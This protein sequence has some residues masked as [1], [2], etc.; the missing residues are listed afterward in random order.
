[1]IG[2]IDYGLGNVASVIN[3]LKKINEHD[4]IFSNNITELGKCEKLILPGVGAFEKGMENLKKANLISFLKDKVE[5]DQIP[6]LGICL[7][8][9]LLTRFSEEGDAE[10]LGFIQAKTKKFNFEMES[11]FP[12]PHMGWNYVKVVRNNKILKEDENLK[13]KFYFV[14]S[15]YVECQNENDVIT[16]SNYGIDFCSSF[17]NNNI[18]GVQFHPEKSHIYGEQL[19]REFVSI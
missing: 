7:G 15:Y 12:I 6:I 1:M 3:M 8:M 16:T 2:I 5:N 4:V 17:N 11:P 19:F 14:H 18:Y 10:G 9:Q 13:M